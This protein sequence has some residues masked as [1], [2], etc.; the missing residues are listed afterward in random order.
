MQIKMAKR[1]D[2]YDYDKMPHGMREYLSYHGYHFSKPMAE[3][4]IS[5]MRDRNGA[6]LQMRTKEQ[7]DT[8]LRANNATPE[9]AKGYDAMYTLHMAISD[10]LGSSIPDEAHAALYVKDLIGDEDGY[11]GIVFTRFLA[12]CSA[13]GMPIPW[14]DLL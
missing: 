8:I 10:F 2:D 11:D 5:M 1:L 3:W 13:K 14:G 4:A 12:D 7:V 9:N 6:K